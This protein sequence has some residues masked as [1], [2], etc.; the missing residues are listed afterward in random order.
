MRKLIFAIIVLQL[1]LLSACTSADEAP[2]PET[3]QYMF[4]LGI[5]L[6]LPMEWKPNGFPLFG[7]GVDMS[8]EFGGFY[9][10]YSVGD[11]ERQQERFRENNTDIQEILLADGTIIVLRAESTIDDYIWEKSQDIWKVQESF[12][13]LVRLPNGGILVAEIPKTSNIDEREIILYEVFATAQEPTGEYNIIAFFGGRGGI[14][15]YPDGWD[16]GWNGSEAPF[17]RNGRAVVS[18]SP[19]YLDWWL[20][21]SSKEIAA[22]NS[23]EIAIH[24]IERRIPSEEGFIEFSNII[25]H[26]VAIHHTDANHDRIVFTVDNIFWFEFI[27]GAPDDMELLPE[28]EAVIYG[29]VE[30]IIE[31][32]REE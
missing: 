26:P 28:D 29:M 31:N 14:M 9:I 3:W 21:G 15:Y 4:Q 18:I 1:T 6:E 10:S 30:S 11:W 8:D 17:L 5:S 25:G 19:R 22:M 12:A 27:F 16:L 7:A 20:H 24:I 13:Y 32:S 23:Q 2:E